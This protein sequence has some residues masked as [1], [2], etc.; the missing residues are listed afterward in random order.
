MRGNVSE[1]LQ[2]CHEVSYFET[3]TDGRAKLGGNCIG[4][5]QG[6]NYLSEPAA[7]RSAARA[8]GGPAGPT[9]G[10]RVTRLLD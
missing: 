2:D 9:Q 3:P 5:I 8:Q 4:V 7:A 1:Y 6:G 10:F